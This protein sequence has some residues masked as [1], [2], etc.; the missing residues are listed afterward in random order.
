MSTGF[1]DC[2][3]KIKAGSAQAHVNVQVC[4]Y[5]RGMYVCHGHVCMFEACV[6]VIS[7][8]VYVRGICMP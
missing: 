3:R 7:M 1:E 8:C 5:V 4:V 2:S 6:Y